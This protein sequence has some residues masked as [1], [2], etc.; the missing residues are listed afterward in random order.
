MRQVRRSRFEANLA[1][2]GFGAF[3]GLRIASKA[4]EVKDRGPRA[5]RSE[6]LQLGEIIPTVIRNMKSRCTVRRNGFVGR[7][8][9]T[10]S[11]GIGEPQDGEAWSLQRLRSR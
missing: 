9:D 5:E 7:R 8:P 2:R 3:L 11:R 1:L 10:L 4:F 6:G